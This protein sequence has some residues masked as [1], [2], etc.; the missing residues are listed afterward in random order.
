MKTI[1]NSQTD[2]NLQSPGLIL[3]PQVVTSDQ[4]VLDLSD[5]SIFQ[6]LCLEQPCA[7]YDI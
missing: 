2:H 5:I 6:K 4:F 3:E 1:S 7:G